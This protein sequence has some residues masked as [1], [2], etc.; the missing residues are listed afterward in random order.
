M[1]K[2]DLV[3]T[4]IS[5]SNEN[6]TK[7]RAGYKICKITPHHM[8]GVLTAEQ[9][10]R[11][12]QN[13]ERQASSNY[14]IGNDGSIA[15]Y[16]DEENRA[17]TS[18]NRLNDYQAITIEVSNSQLGGEWKI[19]DAAWTS[20]VNLCVD[21][22][23]RYNFKLVYDETP[24]GSLTR[25]NMF[26]NTTCPGPYLQ[27]KFPELVKEVNERLDKNEGPVLVERP[28][29]KYKV[30]DVVTINGVYVASN[31]TNKLSPAVKTGTITK[32]IPGTLNPYLLN[33]GDI[34]W[35]N[36]SVI[37]SKSSQKDTKKTNEEIADEIIQKGLW[38][39]GDTRKKNLEDAGYDYNAIQKIINEKLK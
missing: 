1:A 14:G 37:I 35:V 18:S 8:A 9:C 7:G 38:G 24:N 4:V 29:T 33:N 3:S 30:G 19:S 39:T 23:K 13:P 11:I 32:I 28:E 31:S 17:W 21:I 36:E 25:H 2:S 20:L 22:C 12:F 34:G 16:V 10:G 26:T 15:M 5:A 27:S 6:Y